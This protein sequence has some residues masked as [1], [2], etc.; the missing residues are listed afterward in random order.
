MI[1]FPCLSIFSHGPIQV[2]SSPW[3]PCQMT[4]SCTYRCFEPERL[5]GTGSREAQAQ[6]GHHKGRTATD[7][8]KQEMPIRLDE[9]LPQ[10]NYIAR[11]QPA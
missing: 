10:W 9:H 11:P 4:L 5:I 1:E 2:R 7:E 3:V 6:L 8:F